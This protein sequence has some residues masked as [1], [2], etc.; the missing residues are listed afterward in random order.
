[1][2]T[3]ENS[4]K[5]PRSATIVGMAV[6]T[7][8]LSTAGMKVAMRQAARIGPRRTGIAARGA[9]GMVMER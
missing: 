1:M 5:P 7:M 8:V 3:H 9:S 4:A 6:A 2:N